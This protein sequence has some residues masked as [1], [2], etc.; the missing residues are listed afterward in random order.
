[1]PKRAK[2]APIDIINFNGGAA[3]D[4]TSSAISNLNL[5]E[6]NA[7]VPLQNS[8]SSYQW[9]EVLPVTVL[10][11]LSDHTA[12]I[13]FRFN[14]IDKAYSD[15]FGGFIELKFKVMNQTAEGL[16]NLAADELVTIVNM[17]STA[18]WDSIDI[19]AGDQLLLGNYK[20]FGYMQYNNLLLYASD[21][22]KKYN[23]RSWGWFID[24]PGKFDTV[25][26]AADK[27]GNKGA[28]FRK[29]LIA[30]SKT[31]T[32]ITPFFIDL[33]NFNKFIPNLTDLVIKFY[34]Q[35]PEFLLLRGAANTHNYQ[36]VIQRMKFH[37]IRCMLSEQ[38]FDRQQRILTSSGYY[39]GNLIQNQ[40]RKKNFP[41]GERNLVFEPW[42]GYL[43]Q[44]I[45]V[46]MV[47][48][49]AVNGN[50]KN[51]PF[52][53]ELFDARSI[54]VYK[55]EILY[56]LSVPLQIEQ[57]NQEL[58]YFFLQQSLHGSNISFNADDISNGFAIFG[59]DL[60]SGNSANSVVNSPMESGTIR[61][62]IDLNGGLAETTTLFVQG[63]FRRELEIDKNRN[64]TIREAT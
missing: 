57:E 49:A 30:S 27:T 12:P 59:F 9:Q 7:K 48:T 23:M 15:I 58:V 52:N 40:I 53:Y 11:T 10:S 31:V 47:K 3:I 4:S 1:M 28:Q 25:V 13:E 60:T 2:I 41:S 45:L 37:L 63:D 54:S 50:Y 16:V 32:F 26:A 18:I 39:L 44:R 22:A 64:F 29:A 55:N 46:W 35:K 51:N 21:H 17:S 33:M 61:I 14:G 34:R 8:I 6:Y 38:E 56:P 43:P 19:L 5:L 24:D 36:I 62:Q 20:D 42:K